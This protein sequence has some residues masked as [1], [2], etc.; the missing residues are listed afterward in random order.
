MNCVY[1]EIN[2]FG[3]VVCIAEG[4]EKPPR[5]CPYQRYCAQKMVWENTDLARTCERRKLNGRR[6]E[7]SRENS[8][9][10]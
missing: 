6:E 8:G 1:S 5:L 9:E 3:R 4:G 7:G 10:S 2:K